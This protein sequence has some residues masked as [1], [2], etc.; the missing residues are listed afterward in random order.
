MRW[1][2]E[3]VSSG[4]GSRSGEGARSPSGPPAPPWAAEAE[5]SVA[6]AT[7]LIEHQFP[8]LVPAGVELIGTG[9]DNT[10]YLVNGS[11]VF[12]FP[13]RQI[14]VPL[15]TNESNLLPAVAPRL[16]V[17]I[18]VPS[19]RGHPSGGYGWPFLG[20]PLL[21]GRTACRVR[22]DDQQRTA[23]AK[24]LGGFL[25]ALHRFPTELAAR[26]GA[27]GDTIGRLDLPDRLPRCR[28][29]MET[30]A[31]T[32]EPEIQR[33][34]MEVIDSSFDIQAPA[35]TALCHGDL[36]ARHLLVDDQARLCGV[37]D[38][39]DIHLG[40]P[41]VDLS[42]AH[43]FLPPAARPAFL[44]AY[45]RAVDPETWCLAR[46]RAVWSALCIVTYGREVGDADLEWEGRQALAHIAA[47]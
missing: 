28:V 16:P 19:L 36:Y 39:G 21:P 46:F 3:Q 35:E 14:A 33:R 1:L 43:G 24:P 12:R 40:H 34:L 23:I 37:I 5:V 6:L 13:R 41:A 38:W 4:A 17:P 27:P 2:N 20:Y 47:D 29:M 18:P 9:W 32:L 42:V 10:A 25:A 8:A 30:L 11:H 22:L 15:L 45:G 26:L 7:E 31:P 44:R